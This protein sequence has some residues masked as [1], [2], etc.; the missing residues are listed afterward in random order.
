[1]KDSNIYEYGAKELNLF[2]SEA[3]HETFNGS[4]SLLEDLLACPKSPEFSAVPPRECLDIPWRRH[5][6]NYPSVRISHQIS[7]N[8]ILLLKLKRNSGALSYLKS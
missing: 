1:M 2:G 5:R 7:F 6:L 4:K 3:E 8:L